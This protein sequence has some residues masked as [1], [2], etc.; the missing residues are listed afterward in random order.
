MHLADME[1]PAVLV[2]FDRLLANLDWAQRLARSRGVALR[3]HVKTH[4]CLEIAQ[5][6]LERGAIGLTASKV[7]EALV[8]IES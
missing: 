3:P 1:T 7:D 6:Q 8:F 4:K 5:L 2:D